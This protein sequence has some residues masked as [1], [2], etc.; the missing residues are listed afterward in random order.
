M[1]VI[2]EFLACV[3]SRAKRPFAA[4][5]SSFPADKTTFAKLTV[6]LTAPFVTRTV[7]FDA[8]TPNFQIHF[9]ASAAT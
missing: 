1:A 9:V 2:V 4:E 3:C 5:G 8:V 7:A 6:W